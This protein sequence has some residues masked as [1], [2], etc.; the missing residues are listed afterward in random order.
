MSYYK[1]TMSTL[2]NNFS[3]LSQLLDLVYIFVYK[4]DVDL[5]V[6]CQY[7]LMA[8]LLSQ[9]LEHRPRSVLSDE[10]YLAFDR[11]LCMLTRYS[12]TSESFLED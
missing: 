6:M 2:T 8:S 3:L 11:N 1:S 9:Q 10:F 4:L 12:S 7:A 5:R